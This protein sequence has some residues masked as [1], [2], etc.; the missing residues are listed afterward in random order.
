MGLNSPPGKLGH[1]TSMN[2]INLENNFKLSLHLKKYLYS[3][4]EDKSTPVYLC[5]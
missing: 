5:L 2:I 1:A 4:R 3:I